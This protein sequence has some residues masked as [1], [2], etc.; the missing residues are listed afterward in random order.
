MSDYDPTENNGIVRIHVNDWHAMW[1]LAQ[2]YGL[3]SVQVIFEAIVTT[4]GYREHMDRKQMELAV[5]M[6]LLRRSQE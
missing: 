4:V 5:Q 6:Y 1:E 3:R 2:K